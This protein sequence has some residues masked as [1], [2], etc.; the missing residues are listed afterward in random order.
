M[1]SDKIIL[2]K[3]RTF[4]K[5]IGQESVMSLSWS[6]I[7]ESLLPIPQLR[8]FVVSMM[9][10]GL[11]PGF[12]CFSPLVFMILKRCTKC[13]LSPCQGEMWLQSSS[14][15]QREMIVP[16]VPGDISSVSPAFCMCAGKP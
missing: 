2:M 7:S 8:G 13:F 6:L 9:N 12:R 5:L 16:M 4:I 14:Q 11:G 15:P 3:N 10:N 1:I